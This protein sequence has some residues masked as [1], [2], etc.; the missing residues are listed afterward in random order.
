MVFVTV[1]NAKQK[2]M[3]LLAGVDA[4][5]EAGTFGNR[6][7]LMQC[8]AAGAFGSRRCRTV[9][10]LRP[11]EFLE[12]LRRASLVICHGGAGSIIN[13]LQLGQMPI[14]MPRR[15]DLGEHVDDH[16]RELVAALAGQGRVI[17]AYE[18]GDLSEAVLLVP[19]G[20]RPGNK[21]SSPRMLTLIDDA[22]SRLMNPGGPDVFQAI[23]RR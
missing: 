20:E 1:G 11:G 2:F 16:Q 4:L 12:T 7:V 23:Q 19:E 15:K 10:F 3:R 14:V 18:V 21:G 9:D 17:P 8:G 6:D 22:I 5:A 13:V